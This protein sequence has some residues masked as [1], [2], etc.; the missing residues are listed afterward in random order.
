MSRKRHLILVFILSLLRAGGAPVFS[1][2]GRVYEA[3]S[4]DGI[5]DLTLKLIPAN[6][7]KAPALTTASDRTGAYTFNATVPGRYLL[8]AYY[9]V[10][11]VA[12]EVIYL[13]RDLVR[14]IGLQRAL[15]APGDARTEVS[16]AADRPWT[17]TGVV[18]QKGDVFHFVATGQIHWDTAKDAT[19]DPNGNLKKLS[20]KLGSKFAYPVP[21]VGAGGLIAR[22]GKGTPFR[23][24]AEAIKAMPESGTLYLGI[25]Y[26]FFSNNS[27]TFHV[28]IVRSLP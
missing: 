6:D 16:V 28:D 3:N 21:G 5:P 19:A 25:N 20:A 24:G 15:S 23:I 22:V 17:D 1:V 14:D 2:H 11:L 4:R 8:E 13:D 9:G 12:R 7:V 10:T 26:N 18:V 27:G